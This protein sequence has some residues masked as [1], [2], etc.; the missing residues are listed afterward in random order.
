MKP[1]ACLA[2]LSLAVATPLA[3]QPAPPTDGLKALPAVA[4][5]TPCEALRGVD[6]T[7]VPGAPAQISQASTET[8][9]ATG[10]TF[11]HVTGFVAPQVRFEMKLPAQA[12]T[13]RLLMTGCGGLCGMIGMRVEH[14]NDCLPV[15]QGEMAIVAT[16][17]GHEGQGG[18]WADKDPV[19][20]TDFA[21]RGV[22]VVTLA[23][24]AIVAK[25]YGQKQAYAY[26]SGC[27]D[28]GREALMEAERFP[29]DYDGITAGAPASNFTI[30]N[31]FYHAWNAHS[32]TDA[33]GHS[34][35]QPAK[36]P[37]LHAAVLKAC[38]R[39]DGKADG[40]ISDP[41]RCTFDP[42]V[43]QCAPGQSGDTCL[44]PAEVAAVR[45]IYAGAH[46]DQGNRF[47]VGAPQPGSELAWQGVEVPMMPGGPVGSAMF[48]EDSVKYLLNW[49][50]LPAS[51][52]T[53][54]FTFDKATFAA[55]TANN[56][57][58][59]AT[60]PDLST[61]FNR[62]GRLIM[63]HG[64][65][66]Q[67]ISPINTIA[68]YRAVEATL[69][70]DATRQGMRF[71]LFPGVYHCGGGEGPN[72]FDILTPVMAWVE[73]HKAPDGIAAA[74]T[75]Q[76]MMQ[77]PPPADA[78]PGKMDG[79]PP[80][81]PALPIAQMANPVTVKPYPMLADFVPAKGGKAPKAVN[82]YEIY[83][84]AHWAGDSL[85]KPYAHAVCDWNGNTY[86]C[87]TKGTGA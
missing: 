36:L 48:A 33:T 31:S 87:T 29:D 55:M 24:K 82:G 1:L 22:H 80:A 9:Q 69:G 77:G 32:N 60:D 37:A 28:G 14:A 50:S 47:V 19:L 8:D 71:Y 5:V 4:P 79:P 43:I 39:L 7:T 35:L 65:A 58:Y 34:I 6:F 59:G 45:G 27:S 85:Y 68:Y 62:G 18:V 13:Q 74:H 42:S 17:M 73:S 41:T 11:C 84:P 57:L 70:A 56:A 86:S 38:D 67:H 51:W 25:Y 61:F 16:D 63:W 10:K 12:W 44:T 30:Q 53:A 83:T 40:L 3:A 2:A 76:H 52:H 21:Y 66:D 78:K 75:E 26:F 64:W 81:P 46:D 54:D 15:R 23:A 72:E 20:R 49:P